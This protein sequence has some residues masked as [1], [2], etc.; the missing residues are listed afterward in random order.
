MVAD[1]DASVV[2]DPEGMIYVAQEVERSSSR[3]RNTEVG[4]LV[5]LD[6]SK[7]DDPID[8]ITN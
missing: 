3:S 2:V 6:P 1:T 8:S 5:K 7:P 4:Q